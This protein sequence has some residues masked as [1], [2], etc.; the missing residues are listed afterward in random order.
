M[1]IAAPAVAG[2]IKLPM[3]AVFQQGGQST[4][5]LVDA[6]KMTVRAQPVVVAGADGNLVVIAGGLAPGQVVVTAGVHVLT[7]GQKVRAYAE[8]GVALPAPTTPVSD[9][10]APVAA[11]ATAASTAPA[12]SR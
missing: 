11:S 12:A 2:V 7:E 5:W 4:V 1:L 3:S 9:S 10:P 8:P 6:A